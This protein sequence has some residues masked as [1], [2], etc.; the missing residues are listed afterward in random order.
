MHRGSPR[1]S[2]QGNPALQSSYSPTWV[3]HKPTAG[4]KTLR[5]KTQKGP[6]RM[7]QALHREALLSALLQTGPLMEQ[8]RAGDS[9]AFIPKSLLQP[10]VPGAAATGPYGFALTGGVPPFL[11]FVGSRPE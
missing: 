6:E 4:E 1:E 11:L 9:M 10:W 5:L 2:L 3:I 8:G 7:L